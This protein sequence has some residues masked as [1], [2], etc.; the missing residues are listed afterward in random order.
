MPPGSM[1]PPASPGIW[2]SG[3][4]RNAAIA[5]TYLLLAIASLPNPHGGNPNVCLIWPGAGFALAA[6]LIRGESRLVGI[7]V[8]SLLVT[9]Y[10]HYRFPSLFL[11]TIGGAAPG[12]DRRHAD[13]EAGQLPPRPPPRPGR[14]GP[15]RFGALLSPVIGA[16]LGALGIA[17]STGIWSQYDRHWTT[18]WIGD[19]MG[20]LIVAPVL[21]AFFGRGT[22]RHSRPTLAQA[23]VL[24]LGVG[25][26]S[27]LAFRTQGGASIPPTV[28]LVYPAAIWAALKYGARGVSLATLVVAGVAI[29]RA[30]AGHSPLTDSNP[31]IASIISLWLFL[32]VLAASALTLAAVAAERERAKNEA[33]ASR[34]QLEAFVEHT[35]AAVAMFDREMRYLVVSHRW[36]SDYRL[37]DQ[38]LIGKSHYDVFPEI[39][40]E[41][42]NDHRRVLQGEVYRREQDMFLR[43]DG[44]VD[45]LRYELRPW[46]DI[47]GEV[48]GVVMFT[49][50]ITARKRAEDA[51]RA[52]EARFRNLVAKLPGAIYRSHYERHRAIE[53]CSP[54]I[55]DL[56]GYL[57]HEL[58][59][60]ADGGFERIIHPEDRAAAWKSIEEQLSRGSHYIVEYRI[61][62]KDGEERHI[63]DK[64]NRS[65][66]TTTPLCLD[67]ILFDMTD[68]KLREAEHIKSVKL[69]SIGL[70]AGG[71]AHDFNNILTEIGGNIE[72]ARMEAAASGTAGAE[73]R[74]APLLERAREACARATDLARQLLTFSK[75][76]APVKKVSCLAEMVRETV[77][78]VLHGSNC[79]SEL[80]L[81][82]DVWKV[83][84]DEEQIGQVLQ[85]LILNADQAMPGGGRLSIRLE[86]VQAEKIPAISAQLRPVP[87]VCLSVEDRGA[88]IDPQHLSRIFDPYFTTRPNRSGLGLST[89]LSIVTRHGGT[90]LVESEKGYGSLFRIYLPALPEATPPSPSSEPSQQEP[91]GQ[92]RVLVMDDED[93]IR[94]V[95]ETLLK[96]LG[97]EVTLTA[98][99]EE[100][101]SRFLEARVGGDPF[102]FVLLDLTIPGG[103]GG[104]EAVRRLRE[105]DPA[106]KAMVVSGY[107]D[108]PI[109]AD[110]RTYGFTTSLA[111]PFSFQGLR[112]A[113][114]ELETNEAPV[115]V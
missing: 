12:L 91:S 88:G 23:A 76:G 14:R 108:D 106:L 57:P 34:L 40:E 43:H 30:G 9:L 71:I 47:D 44:T 66:S 84:I 105:I 93:G 16:T 27:L 92:G 58:Q 42:K 85:N 83:E 49:E 60:P 114:G 8:G 64:G 87:H 6:V 111:K 68:R 96:K 112:A 33:Q 32:G 89:A 46:R 1:N 31:A 38:E 54:Y 86:N 18:W 101:L 100:A 63:L 22:T 73:A 65:L 107:S 39:G 90:I 99:G 37:Q 80:S 19:M 97:Y 70:L 20:I 5:L 79:S 67:G 48:G 50:V 2:G 52:S 110:C 81:P 98:H 13:A 115:P 59:N 113:I 62:R 35:P 10:G 82:K 69:E 78:F 56:T 109:L 74:F 61:V 29:F 24:V 72:L 3:S 53:T 21:L 4:P 104:K 95:L 103:M 77:S 36:L 41:W 26:L 11:Q 45:W 55:E 94:R 102:A 7:L 75:G 51:L 17:F 15:D 28:Y 25:A